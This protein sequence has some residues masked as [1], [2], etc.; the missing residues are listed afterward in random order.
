MKY[1]A[2]SVL[3]LMTLPCAVCAVVKYKVE[4]TTGSVP[5]GDTEAQVY[6]ELHGRMGSTGR[7]QLKKS[8]NNDR[9]F[10]LGQVGCLL[11]SCHCQVG[12]SLGSCHCQVG[13][14]LGSCE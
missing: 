4:V 8:L 13:H 14:S 9:M 5:K 3:L 7:R 6:I 1:D 10:Q 12:H 11:C 2:Q